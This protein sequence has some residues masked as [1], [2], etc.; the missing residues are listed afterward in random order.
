[1]KW[2][3]V[4]FDGTLAHYEGWIAEDHLGEPVPKM[5]E[6]VK[7][8]LAD[9]RKVKVFTARVGCSGLIS[10]PGL[11][12]DERFANNQRLMIEDWCEKHIGQRLEVTAT[13]DFCMIELWDDRAVAIET[14]TGEIRTHEDT[15]RNWKNKDME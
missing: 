14:N 8:W 6:R 12:D 11:L 15:R 7:D 10:G 5:V 9:G 2:I 1:M 4:D 3:G 13:K